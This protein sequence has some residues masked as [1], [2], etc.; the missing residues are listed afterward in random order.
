MG[1]AGYTKTSV[2]TYQSTWYRTTEGLAS[3]V[4]EFRRISERRKHNP[5][6]KL[7]IQSIIYLFT[8][9]FSSI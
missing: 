7:I 6:Q 4:R 2:P 5:K 8:C 1:A 3:H 9:W